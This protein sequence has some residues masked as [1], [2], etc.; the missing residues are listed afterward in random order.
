MAGEQFLLSGDQ[1]ATYQSATVNFPPPAFQANLTI[2]G[3]QPLGSSSDRFFLVR[4]QGNGDPIQNSELFS[5]Y[6]AIDD[7]AGGLAPDLSQPLYQGSTATPDAYQSPG[8]NGL[9]AGDNY[10]AMGL[11]NGPKILLKLDGFDGQGTFSVAQGQDVSGDD[12]QLSLG[13]ITA[14]NPDQVVCFA[15]GTPITT[16]D[17]DIPVE[18]LKVG[19]KI[20]TYDNG[21]QRIKWIGSSKVVFNTI[22]RDLA[23]IRFEANALGRGQ[24][25]TAIS[26]SPT[27]RIL[28]SGPTA[29]LLF[30]VSEI[31]I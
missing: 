5:I 28:W 24:P 1:L 3:I 11:F 15:Q 16:V 23:P 25:E 22:N 30:G 9:G 18:R 29:E 13:E 7:G 26:V 31:L 17:G 4:T 12:G 20:L 21:F 19:D 27:H 10:L 8:N 6:P 2:S 14:A